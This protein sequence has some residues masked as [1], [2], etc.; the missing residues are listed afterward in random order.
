MS[1]DPVQALREFRGAT[2]EP[3]EAT[4][5]R[6]YRRALAVG[7][8]AVV[9][10]EDPSAIALAAA[11]LAP[12]G[13]TILHTV[14]LSTSVGPGGNVSTSRV[15]AWRRT[16]AP[17]DERSV[18]TRGAHPFEHATAGGPP[19]LYDGRTNTIYTLREGAEL[20]AP[21]SRDAHVPTAT[22]LVR[23]VVDGGTGT[24]LV[25]FLRSALTAG[26]AREEGRGAVGGREA[27]RI[28]LP[29]HMTLL[30]DAETHEPLEWTVVS[31]DGT[32][33]TSRFEA[34]EL[35]PATPANLALLS[36][37]AQHPDAP[38]QATLRMEGVG[39]GR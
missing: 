38:V 5:R 31:D 28:G 29:P 21:R 16:T 32:R 10:S 26:A 23:E 2:P 22:R 20:P 27:I 13:E 37:R 30:V 8:L 34:Y 36:L 11:A 19:Q 39:S 14:V 33:V 3:D 25:P 18:A 17:H 7:V 4:A 6:V 15:E 9:P 1:R 12:S 35:L 24:D